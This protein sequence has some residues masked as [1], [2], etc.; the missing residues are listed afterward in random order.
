MR[1]LPP[2]VL[3]S[4]RTFHFATGSRALSQRLHT[5]YL[6]VLLEHSV[7]AV[8]GIFTLRAGH[9]AVRVCTKKRRAV[10]GSVPSPG[11]LHYPVLLD[12][13]RTLAKRATTWIPA[14]ATNLHHIN[15]GTARRGFATLI[16]G[17]THRI[18]AFPVLDTVRGF[19]HFLHNTCLGVYL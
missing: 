18:T 3:F 9:T 15:A 5:S 7:L 4:V 6:R 14:A 10:W 12:H 11:I 19:A 16:P 17:D 2:F 1:A 8:P 13:N